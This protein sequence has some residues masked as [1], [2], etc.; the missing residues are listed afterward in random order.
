MSSPSSSGDRWAAV[1][2]ATAAAVTSRSSLC[3]LRRRK[4]SSPRAAKTPTTTRP[5]TTNVPATAPLLSKNALVDP[6]FEL[7]WSNAPVGL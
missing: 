4:K 3:R 5:T 7:P 6:P 1:D 2:A